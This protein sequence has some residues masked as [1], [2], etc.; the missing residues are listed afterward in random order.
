M[1][2]LNYCLSR[3]AHGDKIAAYEAAKIM[4]FEKYSEVMVQAQLRKAASLGSVDAM[5]W[6]GF[7]GLSGKLISPESTVTKI[8][9]YN[10][11]DHAYN[12]FVE[13]SKKGDDLSTLVVGT[14]LH[15]GIGIPQDTQKSEEI[16]STV[17]NSVSIDAVV[18]VICLIN[19][20][21][22][23]ATPRGK[24]FDNDFIEKLLY[25]QGG[26]HGENH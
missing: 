4:Q 17:L 10:T 25:N 9:Y 11:Y 12:W 21:H 2:S 19:A 22:S 16:M 6:L 8:S 13:G 24:S 23:S 14:C 1:I 26:Q 15:H 20:L 3:S 7:L 18:P 5:R